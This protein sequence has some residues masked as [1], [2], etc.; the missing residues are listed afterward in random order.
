MDKETRA[1]FP[2]PYFISRRAEEILG[3]EDAF[4][5]QQFETSFDSTFVVS[6]QRFPTQP[7]RMITQVQYKVCN[8]SC[9]QLPAFLISSMEKPKKL[10]K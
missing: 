9:A 1:I 5:S 10:T 4:E 6:F 3:T 8:S 7:R 2:Q